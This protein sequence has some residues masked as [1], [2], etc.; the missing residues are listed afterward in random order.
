VFS[1]GIVCDKIYN[2]E[3]RENRAAF[4]NGVTP[5]QSDQY[6]IVKCTAQLLENR[7]KRSQCVHDMDIIRENFTK[8]GHK[9]QEGLAIYTSIQYITSPIRTVVG[10]QDV[11]T[12]SAVIN[13]KIR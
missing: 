1:D 5:P 11:Y 8:Y 2:Q 9:L 3:Q 6:G 4:V 13:I 12:L 7:E 10:T